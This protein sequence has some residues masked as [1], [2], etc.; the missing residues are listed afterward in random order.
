METTIKGRAQEAAVKFLDSKG[1]IIVEN[2]WAHGADAVDLIAK[3]GD[4]LVFIDVL[5][6]EGFRGMPEEKPD[7]GKFER[8]AVA[9]LAEA[10]GSCNLAIRYDIVSLLVVNSDRALLRHHVNALSAS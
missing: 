9:Y 10:D 7:R 3:D 6:G 1:Y 4:D 2:G 5:V 8:L